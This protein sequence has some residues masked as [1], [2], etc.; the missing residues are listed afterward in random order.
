M[1]PPSPQAQ[2]A[3]RQV[4]RRSRSLRAGEIE[5]KGK[6]C[7]N[8]CV[9]RQRQDKRRSGRCIFAE[10]KSSRAEK[11]ENTSICKSKCVQ[12]QRKNKRTASNY[13]HCHTRDS[14]Y[15]LK[16]KEIPAYAGMTEQK[17][18]RAE[19]FENKGK[20]CL[21]KRP[22]FPSKIDLIFFKLSK[23]HLEERAKRASRKMPLKQ[24]RFWIQSIRQFP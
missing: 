24:Q 5:N 15:L 17:S 2:T 11:F 20:I 19:K 18:S 10:Q 4:H 16:P 6:V 22:H 8:K 14:G 3:Q 13:S 7:K 1:R 12:P 23:P 21:P 9:H